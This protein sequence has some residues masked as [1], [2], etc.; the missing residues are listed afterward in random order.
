MPDDLPP[1]F[2]ER[3]DFVTHDLAQIV[4]LERGVNYAAALLIVTACEAL[5]QLL[6]GGQGG[7][8]RVFVERLMRPHGIPDKVARDLVDAVRNGL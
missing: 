6:Y 2:V 7:R 3:R 5:G 4:Q 8:D 1:A